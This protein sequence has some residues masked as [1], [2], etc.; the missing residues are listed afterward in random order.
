MGRDYPA[1]ADFFHRKL[2]AAFMR[3]SAE[4]DPEKIEALIARGRFVQ[5]EIEALYAL[6]RY[7]AMKQR[8]YDAD[9]IER[10]HR[11][12]EQFIRQMGDE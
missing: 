4:T 12:I 8:Y 10:H 3:N 11:R 7:R 6:R 1:G 9:E 5:K 2:H